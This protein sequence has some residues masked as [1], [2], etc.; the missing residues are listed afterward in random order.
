[1][2]I[3]H[4]PV[5]PKIL[6]WKGTA[7]SESSLHWDSF[8]NAPI[9]SRIV[10]NVHQLEILC[11]S[12]HM[13]F[14]PNPSPVFSQLLPQSSQVYDR[15]VTLSPPSKISVLALQGIHSWQYG[16]STSITCYENVSPQT[17]QTGSLS[18]SKKLGRG[19]SI[20]VPTLHSGQCIRVISNSEK[21]RT[22]I[23]S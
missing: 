6:S 18:D 11:S 1:M 10:E 14:N 23:G 4:F 21:W 8:H 2:R 17:L 7:S 9:N 19:A 3:A 22:R 12:I 5:L 13:A 16:Q 20:I 15:I